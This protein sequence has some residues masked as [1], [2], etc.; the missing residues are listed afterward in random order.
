S[1]GLQD[2]EILAMLRESQQQAGADMR[3]RAL[4][5]ARAEAERLWLAIEAALSADGAL[6]PAHEQE[7]LRAQIDSLRA[8]AAGHDAEA[9][10]RASEALNHASEDFAARR[11]DA[12]IQQA[13]A[14]KTLE[15]F[16]EH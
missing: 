15:Q 1:W 10:T 4:Q 13:M 5:E 3:A 14:G 12:G 16:E 7:R 9:I 2:D 8:A 11:M 6:L